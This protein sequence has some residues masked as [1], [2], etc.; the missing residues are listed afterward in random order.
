MVSGAELKEGALVSEP[1]EVPPIDPATVQVAY[2]QARAARRARLEGQRRRRS[3]G[4]RFWST[5]AV[6]IV[7]LIGIAYGVWHE[8]QQLLGG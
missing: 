1:D 4:M 6:L 3:A 8:L 5:L 2:R 7:A